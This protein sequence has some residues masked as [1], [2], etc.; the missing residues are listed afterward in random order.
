MVGTAVFFNWRTPTKI[1]AS[2]NEQ[3]ANIH[4]LEVE[5]QNFIAIM[6]S[7]Q[8]LIDQLD[9]PGSNVAYVNELIGNK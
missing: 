1:N 5:Q 9:K 3:L 8:N 2:L 4:L 7:A 6:D